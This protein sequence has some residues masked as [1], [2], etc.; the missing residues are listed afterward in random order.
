MKRRPSPASWM[1]ERQDAIN[2]R[3]R[4]EMKPQ[5][6]KRLWQKRRSPIN[7]IG[8]FAALPI[9]AGTAIIEFKGR[10]IPWEEGAIMLMRGANH[11]IKFDAKHDMD[12]RPQWSPAAHVNH[13]CYPNC[14]IK[15][16]GGGLW[17]TSI[18]PV[19]QHEELLIDYGY[20]LGEEFE[21]C[22]CGHPRCRG[23][24]LRRKDW[25]KLRRLMSKVL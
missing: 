10:V 7:G 4:R 11:V 15:K 20:D 16:K 14:A 8:L 22:R 12:A 24:M 9:R 18:R 5:R 6:R 17:L 2:K 3:L 23:L 13:G 1:T 21:P 19:E 25:P